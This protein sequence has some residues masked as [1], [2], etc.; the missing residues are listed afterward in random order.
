MNKERAKRCQAQGFSLI[1][2]LIAVAIIGI[3]AM[4]ALPSYK[5]SVYKARRA[6]G[7]N[8]LLRA[9]AAQERLF[10]LYSSYTNVITKPAGCSGAACGLALASDVSEE[11]FYK[12]SIEALPVG[13]APGGTRCES[14]V[15]TATAQGDQ[16]NDLV[17]K[18]LTLNQVGEKGASGTAPAACW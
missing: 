15:L 12:L 3:I 7:M 8:L 18:D 10:T 13:C 17:C 5:D 9:A 14:Y 16:A 1:E 2:L 11:K 4:V 6:D